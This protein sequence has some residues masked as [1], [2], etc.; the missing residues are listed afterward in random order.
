M[1]SRSSVRMIQF[2]PSLSRRKTRVRD[3]SRSWYKFKPADAPAAALPTVRRAP[4]HPTGNEVNLTPFFMLLLLVP[5]TSAA[6]VVQ[7]SKP[8][9][10]VQLER[11]VRSQPRPE[12]IHLA[13]IDPKAPGIRFLVTPSNGDP[14]GA[15]PGD[16]NLE[17]TRETTLQFITRRHAQLGINGSFFTFVKHSLDTDNVSLVISN[18]HVVSPLDPHRAWVFNITPDH[19]VQI[20]KV[21]ASEVGKPDS[22]LRDAIAGSDLLVEQGKVVAPTGSK[23]DDSHPPRTAVAVTRDGRLL[24]MT[25][26]GRQP[27]FSEGMSLQ[28]VARFLVAHAA[29]KALNLDGG[30]STTMAIADPQPRIINFPSDHEPD[31]HAGEAR[32]VGVN[33]GVFARPNPDYQPLPPIRTAASR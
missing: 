7:T 30:G 10:G 29:V 18:G 22:Q 13:I 15:L 28:E 8:F 4:H 21:T 2:C 11:I 19:R 6:A 5:G 20:R 12:I 17:T 27:G 25:V 32:A 24:L 3:V 9:V 23:F 16:P 14:N 33:L 1:I 26:D 31:G